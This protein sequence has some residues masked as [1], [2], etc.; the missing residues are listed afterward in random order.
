MRRRVTNSDLLF[1][2][3]PPLIL[4]VLFAGKKSPPSLEA[5]RL[6]CRSAY[7]TSSDC[8]HARQRTAVAVQFKANAAEILS[9]ARLLL[10]TPSVLLLRFVS[11]S[12]V[13]AFTVGRR[14]WTQ[15]LSKGQRSETRSA[16]LQSSTID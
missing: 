2:I 9:V 8:A 3:A 5:P 15:S 14:C 16:A 11:A 12:S 10:L 1:L 4:S 7:T 6:T 13:S